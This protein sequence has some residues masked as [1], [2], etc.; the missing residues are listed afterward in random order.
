MILFSHQ[1]LQTTKTYAAFAVCKCCWK[2]IPLSLSLSVDTVSKLFKLPN[3]KN[4]YNDAELLLNQLD[5]Q[6]LN[7][8][9]SNPYTK[10]LESYN[11]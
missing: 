2:D 10:S 8:F 5:P 11:Y 3:D 9:K 1:Q 7:P 4:N 6:I